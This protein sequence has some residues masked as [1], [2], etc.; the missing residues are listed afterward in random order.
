[1]D[2]ENT[3]MTTGQ[4]AELI[5]YCRRCGRKLKLE[6]SMKAGYGRICIQKEQQEQEA[7]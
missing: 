6:S 2:H 4:P 3:E 5:R 7:L 1:M